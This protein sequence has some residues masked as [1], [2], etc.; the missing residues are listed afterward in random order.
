M[1]YLRVLAILTFVVSISACGGMANI[2]D[3]QPAE[4]EKV[5]HPSLPPPIHP[6]IPDPIVATP[7]VTAEW[8][9]EIEAGERE[10]YVVYGFEKDDWL[11]M[12]QYDERK[13]TYI[14]KLLN[15]IKYY[16]HPDL[17]DKKDPP[18]EVHDDPPDPESD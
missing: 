10:P 7:G 9:E 14:Q 4:V 5:F 11:S 15:M 13:D 2:I 8:N 12:G 18:D 1:K 17:Q 6:Q 3:F 16:G